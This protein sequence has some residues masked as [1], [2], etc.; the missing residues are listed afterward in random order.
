MNKPA[1][2]RSGKQPPK[3]TETTDVCGIRVIHQERVQRARKETA[4]YRDIQRLA[5]A[6]QAL[7]IPRG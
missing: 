3:Q 5:A 1:R 4:D 2:K 6:F 7:E